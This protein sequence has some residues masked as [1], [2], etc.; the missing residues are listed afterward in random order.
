M[1]YYNHCT[2]ELSNEAKKIISTKPWHSSYK[3]QLL[4]R[5]EDM[6]EQG[7]MRLTNTGGE[8]VPFLIADVESIVTIVSDRD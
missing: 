8:S 5:V 2:K 7:N 3:E 4:S 1:K 6:L